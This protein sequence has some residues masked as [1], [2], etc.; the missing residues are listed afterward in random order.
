MKKRFSFLK[1]IASMPPHL[2]LGAGTLGIA[3]VFLLYNLTTALL[4]PVWQQWA[5]V[6]ISSA[7]LIAAGVAYAWLREGRL[8]LAGWL[9]LLSMLV[10]TSSVVVLYT[11][12]ALLSAL[13]AGIY[14]L[15]LAPLTLPRREITLALFIGLV[16]G[17]SI[18]IFDFFNPLQRTAPL[19]PGIAWALAALLVAWYAATLVRQFP[20]LDLRTKFMFSILLG[21]AIIITSLITYFINSSSRNTTQAAQ[22]RLTA[23]AIQTAQEIDSFMDGTLELARTAAVLPSV[24]EY[25]RDEQ[26]KAEDTAQITTLLERLRAT[27]PAFIHSY[28]LVD[29]KGNLLA[30]APAQV[31]RDAYYE[32]LDTSYALRAQ[33]ENAFIT[34]IE[35]PPNERSTLA[36]VVRVSGEHNEPV[37]AL[38]VRYNS[39]ILQNIIASHNDAAGPQSFAVLI[40]NNQIVLAH[41]VQPQKRLQTLSGLTGVSR[42]ALRDLPF[43]TFTR[44]PL[45]GDQAAVED[46]VAIHSTNNRPWQVLFAQAEETFL[47]PVRTQARISSIISL[48]FLL[49]VTAGA[50]A[51]TNY[52]V[53]PLGALTRTAEQVAAGDLN[54]RAPIFSD[55]ELGT[56]ARTFNETT[57]Q[58]QH[59]LNSLEQQVQERTATLEARTHYLRASAE[60]TAAIG[61]TLNVDALI[62][63]VVNTIRLRFDLYYVG[64]F[65]LDATGEWAVLRAG[66]GTAGEKMLA[67]GHRI[68]VGSGMIGWSILHQQPRIAQIAEE[69]AVRLT[70]PELPLTRSEAALPLA[71]RG[72]VLGALTVQ[73]SRPNAFDEDI[74]AILQVMANQVA[75]ALD[76]ARLFDES[77]RALQAARRAFGDFTRQAWREMLRTRPNWGYRYQDGR[78]TP[79]VTDWP[80]EMRQVLEAGQP[81]HG[82]APDGPVLTLP[83]LVR[84]NAIG[85]LQFRKPA[86]ALDW[87]SDEIEAL[88]RLSEQIALA[89][90]NARL[91]EESQ[92]R[93]FQ[94]QVRGEIVSRV[95]QQ[96]DLERVLDA[97]AQ[98]IYAALALEEITIQ[99]V[100]PDT[101]EA[102][103]HD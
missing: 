58:L 91:Y 78:L 3:V 64:L 66:T 82:R 68:K 9:L 75:V 27:N 36:F 100:S 47:A 46:V 62:Q 103:A 63:Q 79:V 65:L 51:L 90:D 39:D 19:S 18:Y 29:F 101:R 42:F 21:T 24:Q 5:F 102:P 10:L 73:S 49:S 2:R 32:A 12:L 92:Q 28:T 56:L 34:P 22:Q 94:E 97:A 16:G 93:A 77:Q 37:G 40:D 57:T 98:E 59:T 72:R 69:D 48:L 30:R 15:L 41:G 85:V 35:V 43:R 1:S 96:T 95:R 74:L 11:N 8:R 33:L 54:A 53:R 99:L 23:A 60:V 88:Q 67:R 76:N 25:A 89:L 71:S 50:F 52:L 87:A 81:T 45:A 83:L 17:S 38:I 44:L 31:Q 55:D 4:N 14:A 26:H 61:T 13:V 70:A 20:T 84:G 86:Q 80:P 6:A 7:F